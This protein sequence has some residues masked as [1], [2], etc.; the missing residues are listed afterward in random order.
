MKKKLT[1]RLG[2]LPTAQD[3]KELVDCKILSPE[4]A[5]EILVSE[6]DVD[7]RTVKSLEAEIKFLRDLAQKLS[8]NNSTTIIE[9][10]REVEK[11]YHRS[12]WWSPYSTW[13]SGTETM[14]LSSTTTTTT[15]NTCGGTGAGGSFTAVGADSVGASNFFLSGSNTTM[16]FSD[17][18]S[19]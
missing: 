4:E 2:K 1:W 14:N 19:F 9:T 3:L 13:C 15:A 11:P 18:Q 17:I 5:K 12:P 6:S 10:I 16:D 8:N 7:E